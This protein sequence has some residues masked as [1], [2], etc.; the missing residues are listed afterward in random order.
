MTDNG[1]VWRPS[2]FVRSVSHITRSGDR[3]YESGLYPD[4]QLLR[5][6]CGQDTDA[7]GVERADSLR[8]PECVTWLKSQQ[9]AG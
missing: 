9:S 3:V 6:A 2:M 7:S 1:L 5:G 8:C 4:A